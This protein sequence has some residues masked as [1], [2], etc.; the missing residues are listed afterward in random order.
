MNQQ[1]WIFKNI[2]LGAF[3]GVL[4]IIL[5]AFAAH[6]LE[7]IAD[8]K[9]VQSFKTGVQYQFLQSFF[10]LIVAV[11]GGLGWLNQKQSKILWITNFVGILFF[12]FSIYILAFLNIQNLHE[13]KKFVGPITPLGGL[14]LITTW[15]IFIVFMHKNFKNNAKD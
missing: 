5:G 4:S 3:L 14:I 8:F 10:A 11:M 9:V 1:S 6:Q 13:F 15:L 2:Q 7:K 12:S